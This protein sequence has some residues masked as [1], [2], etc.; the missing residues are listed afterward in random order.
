MDT[1]KSADLKM[2]SES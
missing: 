1:D 2:L